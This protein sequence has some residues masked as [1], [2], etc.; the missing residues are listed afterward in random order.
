[1]RRQGGSA[2]SLTV[3]C[4]SRTR[5]LIPIDFSTWD[6]SGLPPLRCE[7]T[8]KD[9]VVPCPSPSERCCRPALSLLPHPENAKCAS[10]WGGFDGAPTGDSDDGAGVPCRGRASHRHSR[11]TSATWQ[12]SALTSPSPASSNPDKEQARGIGAA[13]ARLGCQ[14]RP[15]LGFC[16]GSPWSACL[17]A[18]SCRA[19][20]RWLALAA[21]ALGAVT[22]C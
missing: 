12:P 16:T 13:A 10:L 17:Y 9:P 18:D 15:P 14:E 11:H 20:G 4:L 1:L 7:D 21:R 8:R 22:A 3:V 19:T 6:S 5:Q 2:A